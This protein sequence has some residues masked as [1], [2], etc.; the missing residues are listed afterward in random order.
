MK[1][2]ILFFF[3]V[4]L[5]MGCEEAKHEPFV[6][7]GS[8][9]GALSNIKVENLPGAAKIRY[10]LPDDPNVLYVQAEYS[11]ASGETRVVKSSVS[12]N[13]VLLEGFYG[14]RER[15]IKLFTVSRSE[16]PSDEPSMVTIN[17]LPSPIENVRGTLSVFETFGGVGVSFFNESQ[18]SYIVYTLYKDTETGNWVEHDRYYVNDAQDVRFAARGLPSEPKEFGIYFVD[19]WKNHSDTLIQTL[20]P[21]YEEEMDKTLWS[22]A[23]LFDDYYYPRY[24]AYPLNMLWTPGPATYFLMRNDD[25]DLE[26]PNWFTIDLGRE[27]IFGRMRVNH[28]SHTGT[29]IYA[30]GTPRVFE[31]YGS[32]VKST[33][34]DDWTLL[35]KFESIKPSGEPLGTNT[36]DDIARNLA[37]E[38]YDF[39]PLDESFRYIRFKAL[40]TWGGDSSPDVALLELTFWGQAAN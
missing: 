27:Y 5:W 21:L 2:R 24:P 30:L 7:N 35:G 38:D 1:T 10:A 33:N 8:V 14:T 6:H 37:G 16:V 25:P 34:W 22:N 28:L 9:P 13:Y 15:G 36:A 4:L 19:K 32:N 40:E 3:T 29:W 17:P 31:I 23:M 26:L 12:K 11:L 39:D 18:H 20:T